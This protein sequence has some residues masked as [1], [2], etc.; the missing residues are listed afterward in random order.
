MIFCSPSGKKFRSLRSVRAYLES[1]QHPATSGQALHGTDGV[2]QHASVGGTD[3]T[4]KNAAY[5]S[6]LTIHKEPVVQ[7]DASS[8]PAGSAAFTHGGASDNPALPSCD[9][10]PISDEACCAVGSEVHSLAVS[11]MT[12]A[13]VSDDQDIPCTPPPATQSDNTSSALPS[14]ASSPYF[15]QSS[16]ARK[17]SGAAVQPQLTCTKTFTLKYVPPRSPYNLIQE[18]LFHDPWK[19]LVA[20]IFLNK[21]N[22]KLAIPRMWEYFKMC[23]TPQ[24]GC[25]ADRKAVEALLEPLG[26]S[27]KRAETL[28][29]FSNEFITK[30]WH[31]PNELY[32]IGKY[33]NDSY[34]IFCLGEWKQVQPRDHKLNDY[35][36]WLC[37]QHGYTPDMAL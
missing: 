27:K 10:V 22:G 33:G 9:A 7:V 21:T 36:R 11:D 24:E 25:V 34:R 19:L 18:S 4:Q 1:L 23:S 20:T 15:S 16:R 29:R 32:G 14:S 2:E 5:V 12:T 31:Y 6:A 26:L 13:A 3:S 37:K 35:H 28:A 8:L 17:A 30:T